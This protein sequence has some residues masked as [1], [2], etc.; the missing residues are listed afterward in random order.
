MKRKKDKKPSK[1]IMIGLAVIL[2]SSLLSLFLNK[3]ETSN[4]NNNNEITISVQ[5]IISG[6]QYT[7][8]S[9]NLPVNTTINE[10]LYELGAGF[11]QDGDV[12]NIGSI[13]NSY[14]TSTYWQVLVNNYLTEDYN[15]ELHDDDIIIL[16][17][18]GLLNFYNITVG[19]NINGDFE[20]NSVVIQEGITIEYIL[21]NYQSLELVNNTINC[22]FGY[23]NNENNTW[24]VVLN[25]NTIS[26]YSTLLIEDNQ[27][28]FTY[29]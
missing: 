22:L 6:Q 26:N 2:M 10:L 8:E 14:V 28:I 13:Q 29:E 7:P 4:N 17:Y 9:Q 16:Y 21:N 20:N 12:K 11:E 3:D 18:G 19:V 15:I 27:L 1:I 5:F 25:N 23:C 24:S